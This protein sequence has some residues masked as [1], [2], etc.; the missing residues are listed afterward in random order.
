MR[1][2]D[3]V[4]A[5]AVGLEETY[6]APEP[7]GAAAFRYFAL[8]VADHNPSYVDADAAAQAG[9]ATIIAPPTLIC[10]TNQYTGA[11]PD[12]HGYIGHSWGFIPPEATWI[13]GGNEYRF[14]RPVRPADVLVV[15]WRLV[16]AR[17]MTTRAG[18]DL[19][20]VVSEGTYT[21]SRDEFLAW[22]R[23]VM[24]FGDLV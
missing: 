24:F 5:A 2:S 12:G 20:I 9:H 6:K 4:L 7:I 11:P 13:R 1:L 8:A 15:V 10:E 3:D 18:R 23:E 22:N 16:E 14:G 17:N 19:V 21:D